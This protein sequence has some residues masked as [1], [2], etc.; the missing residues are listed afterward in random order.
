V[1]APRLIAP[2]STATVSS[3]TPTL[4]WEL[5]AGSDGASVDVCSDRTCSKIVSTFTAMGQSG[6]PPHAL[7]AGVYF[8][9]ARGVAEAAGCESIGKAES[10]V[11]EFW[12]GAK[13]APAQT[14]WGTTSDVNGDGYPDVLV[15][16][17][18][19][20]DSDDGALFV[21][22][23]GPKGVATTPV[24]LTGPTGGYVYGYGVANAGDIDGDGFGDVLV[25]V[26]G[27]QDN[28]GSVYFY[29]G[30]DKGLAS[31][32]TILECP[33][34]V[35]GCGNVLAALGDLNG[36]GYADVAF[37][38][39]G[40]GDT[41]GYAYVYFGGP[42]GLVSEPLSL[43]DALVGSVFGTS[44]AGADVNGD[45]YSDL[46]IGSD[47]VG[48]GVGAIYVYMG[49]SSG[50]SATP[51]TL[52]GSGVASGY[53][54]TVATL[55]DVNGD[56]LPDVAVGSFGASAVYVYL[57]NATG[58]AVPPFTLTGP[59]TEEFFGET[60]AAGGDINGDG[61]SD[62]LVGSY[63]GNT[64][65]V[66]LGTSSGIS[67]SPWVIAPP[68]AT[69]DVFGALVASAGDVDHDGF[70]DIVATAVNSV[71]P[72]DGVVFLM[73]GGKTGLATSAVTLTV[74]MDHNP[75]IVAR[76]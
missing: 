50:I 33:Q 24:T 7:A 63:N 48:G 25:G 49:S 9:R 70:G 61:L 43:T 58:V 15:G 29:R 16:A 18:Y 44:I 57:G 34:V 52:T 35:T 32:P 8:W 74:A 72:V 75:L 59:A 65:Y 46:F 39:P 17:P 31:S 22:L 10:P 41:A 73:K 71:G 11:W 64:A 69:V 36:D 28:F 12:V 20:N 2:L 67:T 53:V 55:G 68:S 47:D 54:S 38:A 14:S 62:L 5:A 13:S 3:Q 66:Y 42:D 60:L 27:D 19:A 76:E 26:P 4:H 6:S 56:G 1:K 30:S 51:F 40:L 45:G 23:G 21:F 37:G